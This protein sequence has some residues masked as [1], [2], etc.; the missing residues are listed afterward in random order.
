MIALWVLP[1]LPLVGFLANGLLGT[2]LG[3]SFVSAV[4]VGSVVDLPHISVMVMGL[5]DWPN[6]DY[7]ELTEERLLA[8]IRNILGTQ[9]HALRSP[10]IVPDT[11]R[12]NPFEVQSFVGVP[13]A[14]FPR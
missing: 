10:P 13:V 6:S 9:V 1:A 8:S 11:D 3:K 7:R 5:E 14:P 2:R 12:S 4:G